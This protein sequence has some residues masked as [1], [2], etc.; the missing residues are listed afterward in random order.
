V[1][2]ATIIVGVLAFVGTLVGAYCSNNKT[3]ALVTYRLQA[4][5]KKVEQHNKV[6]ERMLIAE[7]EI[8]TMK[9]E[10]EKVEV[11]MHDFEYK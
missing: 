8:K 10:I 5:E 1:D 4:L 7:N 3:V 9:K 6:V 11:E 2:W